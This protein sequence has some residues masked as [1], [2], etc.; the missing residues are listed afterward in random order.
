MNRVSGDPEQ[1]CAQR[2]TCSG[3]SGPDAEPIPVRG[4][5]LLCAVCAAGGCEAP[6]CGIE[7]VQGLLDALW[8]Y[9]Y[10]PIRVLADI[11]VN[12]A[13]YR[14]VYEDRGE[15][16]LPEGYEDRAADYAGRRKDLEVCRLL[17][18][19]PG[20]VLPAWALY[21]TLF[22]RLASIRSVCA[23][24][25]AQSDVWPRC[26]HAEAGYYE[27]IRDAA[28]TSLEDQTEQGEALDGHGR[29]AMFRMRT[30]EDMLTA[31]DQSAG[32][33]DE[34]ADHL[35]IRPQHLL[36][37]LCTME[38]QDPLIQDNLVELRKRMEE[39][40]DIPVTVVEGCC[41]VCDPCNV[42]HPGE[43]VCYT[44]H[45]KNQLR[46]LNILQKLDIEPG[47]TLPA[48]E[49]Y[50]RI[51]ERIGSLMEVCGWGDGLK[52]VHFWAPCGGAE[53]DALE[54]ARVRGLISNGPG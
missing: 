30:R 33:I 41:M 1:R 26:P 37:I 39:D 6:P 54:R 35:Y 17:G 4:H 42:Y 31:K 28:P 20:S 14:D 40:P 25:D 52:T 50:A 15:Q 10:V 19:A 5:H 11:E 12:R 44:T 46:D 9:P 2:M 3:L 51:Y 47:A 24:G 27:R 32:F 8:E 22:D 34:E 21:M 18:I 29:W 16:E 23:T 48:G 53:G 38:A 36:C 13:H 7:A 43:H 49:L 45:I